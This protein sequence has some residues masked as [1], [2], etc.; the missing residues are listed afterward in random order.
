MR[1]AVL[2]SGLLLLVASSADALNCRKY[3]RSTIAACVR[4]CCNPPDFAVPKKACII[5]LRAGAIAS[6]KAS[7]KQA[8][9]KRRCPIEDC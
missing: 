7:G 1:L 6:C 2:A 4:Q 3:C 5:G 8:C 9:P